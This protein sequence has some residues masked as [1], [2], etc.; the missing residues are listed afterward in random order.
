MLCYPKVGQEKILKRPPNQ[1]AKEQSPVYCQLQSFASHLITPA[2]LYITKIHISLQR[3]HAAFSTRTCYNQE[4]KRF[5]P[6]YISMY[7]CG[8]YINM[9][10]IIYNLKQQWND[11][12]LKIILFY[13]YI[14][15]KYS[16]YMYL[17]FGYAIMYQMKICC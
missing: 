17:D 6:T 5:K 1:R 13:T 8:Y 12:V 15:I 9:Q 7:T 10:Y 16:N 11:R 3:R 2:E 14:F 4:R